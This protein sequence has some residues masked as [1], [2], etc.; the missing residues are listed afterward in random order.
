MPVMEAEMSY[1]LLSAIWSPRK[2]SEWYKFQAKSKS[3]RT[4]NTDGIRSSPGAG[5]N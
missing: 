3:L 4:K 1:Y 5:E 2:A